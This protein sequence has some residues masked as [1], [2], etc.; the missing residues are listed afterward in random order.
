[1]G[2]REVPGSGD[3][4]VIIGW[5]P[6]SGLPKSYWRDSTAWCKIFVNGMLETTGYKSDRNAMARATLRFGEKCGP[7]PGALMVMPRGKPPSGHIGI[8]EKV[9]GNGRYVIT[10]EGNVSDKVVRKRR[11]VSYALGFRWPIE[12]L[13]TPVDI[14]R[15]RMPEGSE[16]SFSPRFLDC[17]E[18]TLRW[19]G[20]WSNDPYDTGGATMK[21]VIQRRYD[22]YRKREGLPKRSVRGIEDD[23]LQVIYKDYY[24]DAVHGDKIPQG[25]DM[26]VFDYG[27][28]SGPSRSI[29]YLQQVLG[30]EADGHWGPITEDALE[31]CDVEEKIKS[32]CAARRSFVRQIKT[33]WRF[34]KGWERRI[35]GLEVAAL[36]AVGS[37][38]QVAEL[39]IPKPSADAQSASQGRAD[40]EKKPVDVKT[41]G[42]VAVS[43]GG[44][45]GG[46]AATPTSPIPAP[47]AETVEA[48]ASWE[49]FAQ[50]VQSA[51]AM[52][53][54]HWEWV[55][56]ALGIWAL[57]SY[58]LPYFYRETQT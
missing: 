19:E 24:W 49:G 3:N 47:P 29:R 32:L 34:G 39:P 9:E 45:L 33:Y 8:V 36:D 51:G 14:I 50:T 58:G 56:V 57:I 46:V 22:A 52:A 2:T 54:A 10:I 18:E 38:S 12:K 20:G 43:A 7:K 37:E 5:M 25:L 28:N 4:D 31:N 30:V 44:A 15:E 41:V 53:T 35:N 40:E 48:I 16:V 27:V 11:P 21:G 26:A 6:Y 1:M 13:D 23:E 17:L 55:L 42:T